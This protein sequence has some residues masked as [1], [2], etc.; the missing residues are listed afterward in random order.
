MAK[1]RNTH[2]HRRRDTRLDKVDT[3]HIIGK[4]NYKRANV[5]ED[6]NKMLISVLK[7]RAL[8]TLVN[9]KQ[10]I[11]SKILFLNKQEWNK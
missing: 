4:C 10:S 7:H 9:E 5:N 6:T 1:N 2:H 8:N 3:H 11:V